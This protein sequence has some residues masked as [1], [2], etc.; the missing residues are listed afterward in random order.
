MVEIAK[1]LPP[2]LVVVELPT[3]SLRGSPNE[4]PAQPQDEDISM[5][6]DNEPVH[7]SIAILPPS[8]ERKPV[9]QDTEAPSGYLREE[10]VEVRDNTT[11][12]TS[13]VQDTGEGSRGLGDEDVKMDI[14]ELDR[15]G[16]RY[17]TRSESTE[18]TL[19]SR[20]SSRQLSKRKRD[21]SMAMLDVT[22]LDSGPSSQFTSSPADLEISTLS[23]VQPQS[24][25]TPSD[26]K[27]FNGLSIFVDLAIKNR[28]DLLKDIKVGLTPCSPPLNHNAAIF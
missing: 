22:M 13:A 20:R 2:D 3:R 4:V 12:S 14:S 7:D 21:G 15:D 28:S 1:S 10:Q 26:D 5:E 8:P 27:I 11:A 6:E 23:A 24:T 17:E 19:A 18:T 16:G 25:Q 9:V